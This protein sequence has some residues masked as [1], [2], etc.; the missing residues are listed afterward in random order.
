[1]VSEL[2]TPPQV[3]PVSVDELKTHLRIE[4]TEESEYLDELERAAREYVEGLLGRKLITQVWK[5]YYSSWPDGNVFE[6]PYGQLQAVSSVAYVDTDGE[7]HE[8]S[9][10]VYDVDTASEPGKVALAYNQ[11]WPSASLYPTNPISIQFTCGYGDNR[12]AVPS[13]LRH[14][15]KL[16]V[17]HLYENRE[18]T[19]AGM[20]IQTVPIGI[21]DMLYPYRLWRF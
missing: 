9:T 15:I 8:V 13:I 2:V 14:A 21:Y 10:D 16:L 6:I 18:A 20:T 17:G 4:S 3:E 5:V 7:S 12:L 1:M 11:S 19:I